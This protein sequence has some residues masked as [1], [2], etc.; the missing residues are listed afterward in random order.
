MYIVITTII[1]QFQFNSILYYLCAESTATRPITDTAQRKY[2]SNNN[3]NNNSSGQSQNSFQLQCSNNNDDN[4]NN[5]PKQSST[6]L[7]DLIIIQFNSFLFR[8][9]T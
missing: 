2:S 8:C 1:I 7:T 5:R 4:N 9:E 3:N 6:N